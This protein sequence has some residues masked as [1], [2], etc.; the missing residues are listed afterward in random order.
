MNLRTLR[1][2]IKSV[3][4]VKKITKAMMLVS[5]IKSKK[6][7]QMFFE[8]K[9]YHDYLEALLYRVVKMNEHQ[10]SHLFMKNEVG[11]NLVV[12]LSSN[13]GL[14]GAF[15]YSLFRFLLKEEGLTNSDFITV[16]KKGSFFVSNINRSLIADF[17]EDPI[18]NAAAVFSL[19]IKLFN[20]KKYDQVIIVY[21]R[22]IT[23]FRTMPVAETLLPVTIDETRF[24]KDLRPF[25]EE[26]IIEPSRERV[27]D[28]ILRNYIEEKIRFA[29]LHNEAGEHSS[30]MSAMKNATDN[31]TDIIF[32][33]TLL[34]NKLRQEKITNELLDISTAKDSVEHSLS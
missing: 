15:N 33:L 25:Y 13:K 17:S 11:K 16:G 4:N 3:T 31:A 28:M 34:R 2:K 20:E 1:K 9:P 7:Q 18:L 8:S 6:A 27:F 22:F 24:Q 5:A 32:E 19:S 12:L 30:R 10:Q 21:N 23:T 26:Y 14:C 29:I